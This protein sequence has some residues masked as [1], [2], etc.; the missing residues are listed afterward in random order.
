MRDTE[1]A[2][3][4]LS[5]AYGFLEPD[6]TSLAISLELGLKSYLLHR[7]YSD[8]WNARHIRHDL[9]MALDLA[10]E[11]EFGGVTP[12]L[13]ALIDAFSPIYRELHLDRCLQAAEA[14]LVM[15]ASEATRSMLDE[16]SDAIHQ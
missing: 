8:D 6:L 11:E 1:L 9:R 10:V 3:A 5:N 2:E 7:G 14:P 16:I 15:I 4:F 13:E 12:A